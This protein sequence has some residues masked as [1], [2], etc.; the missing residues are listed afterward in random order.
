MYW[1]IKRVYV[2]LTWI[3]NEISVKIIMANFFVLLTSLPNVSAAQA[4]S[5]PQ[6]CHQSWSPQ[7]WFRSLSLFSRIWRCT[8]IFFPRN[9]VSVSARSR[10]CAHRQIFS[11]KLSPC[12]WPLRKWQHLW[13]EAQERSELRP[14]GGRINYW[15]AFTSILGQWQGIIFEG[16][17][18]LLQAR[19]TKVT[20][21]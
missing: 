3:L 21:E 13:G 9:S 1:N 14:W 16:T 4:A 2:N 10:L 7:F 19:Q 18:R 15:L 12:A 11:S 6:S 20:C 17:L 5:C 8:W